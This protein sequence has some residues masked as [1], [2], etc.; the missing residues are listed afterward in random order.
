[1]Q[2]WQFK[3]S[4]VVEW[5]D[6]GLHAPFPP[7]KMLH[8]KDDEQQPLV[9][10]GCRNNRLLFQFWTEAKLNDNVANYNNK[11]LQN[12]QRRRTRLKKRYREWQTTIISRE[13][14]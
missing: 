13:W 1:M 9:T 4:E 2:M 7:Q 10:A 5:K 14:R 3:T 6:R 12:A 8:I 11:I